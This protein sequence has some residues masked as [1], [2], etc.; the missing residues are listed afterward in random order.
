MFTPS[1]IPRSALIILDHIEEHGPMAPRE[2]SR[3]S[4]VPLRTV[5]FALKKLLHQR[6]LHKTPNFMDMRKTLYYLN[7]DRV[8][9]LEADLERL[10]V[11]TGLHMRAI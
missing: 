5:T 2:L 8:R 10:R 11:L 7:S 6:L 9:E 3:K 4:K 1:D